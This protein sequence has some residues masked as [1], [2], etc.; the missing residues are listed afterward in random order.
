M[1]LSVDVES[2]Q[3]DITEAIGAE[4]ENDVNFNG[5]LFR[6]CAEM[7]NKQPHGGNFVATLLQAIDVVQPKQ[8]NTNGVVAVA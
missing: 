7:D 3:D 4:D 6:I 1:S 5:V 8:S 2:K